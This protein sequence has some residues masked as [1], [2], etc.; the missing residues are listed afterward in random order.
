MKILVVNDDGYFAPGVK[1]LARVASKF[2]QVVVVAPDSPRSGQSHAVTLVSPLRLHELG[3]EGN[4]RY[5]SCSG[6]PADCVKLAIKVVF[7]GTMPDYIFSG[8]NHGSNTAS[9]VVYS[10]TVAGLMEA[11][12]TDV[13][14]V[15][16]SLMDHS[17]D[18]DFGPFL[19]YVEQIMGKCI[20]SGRKDICW[21]V[22]CPAVPAED[23]KGIKVCRLAKALWDE[24]AVERQDPAGRKYYWLQGDFIR[25]DEGRDTDLY[26]ADHAYV[27]L[28]PLSFDWT[29]YRELERIKDLF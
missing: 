9:N 10:G 12:L 14:A 29:D 22:N 7:G 15:A 24:D 28:T 3:Q 27:T 8:I 26:Y 1:H 2:G 23:L 13:P 5:F 17:L 19:P 25:K 16:F 6:T 20:A 21:S 4:I 11:A 18:A